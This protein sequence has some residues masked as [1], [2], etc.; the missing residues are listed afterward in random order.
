METNEQ[1]Q[2]DKVAIV[3]ETETELEELVEE[4]INEHLDAVENIA[5]GIDIL[6]YSQSLLAI[7]SRVH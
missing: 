1:S 2:I 5:T 7:S 3:K 6:G 4:K